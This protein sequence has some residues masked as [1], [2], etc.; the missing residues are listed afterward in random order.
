MEIECPCCQH[1]VKLTGDGRLLLIDVAT[2]KLANQIANHLPASA[3]EKVDDDPPPP[4]GDLR[5]VS[6]DSAR[7]RVATVAQ[8]QVVIREF[9]SNKKNNLVSIPRRGALSAQFTAGN[10]HLVVVTRQHVFIYKDEEWLKPTVK[11]ETASAD[12]RATCISPDG[13]SIVLGTSRSQVEFYNLSDGKR[14]RPSLKLS[15]VPRA[16][17]M[18]SGGQLIIGN[19]MGNIEFWN[20][21]NGE[22][23]ARVKAHTSR[24]NAIAAFP[25]GHSVVTAGRDRDVTIWDVQSTERI[26]NLAG[27]PR[28]VFGIA[29]ASDGKTMATCGLAGDIRIWRTE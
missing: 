29:I 17:V 14:R 2:G 12:I 1:P 11:I 26:T 10:R 28:Q 16:M 19:D 7:L 21:V 20:V 23:R 6:A 22:R 9:D 24:I 4:K 25:D 15:S 13:E 3:V 18:T 5:S 27:H 8:S